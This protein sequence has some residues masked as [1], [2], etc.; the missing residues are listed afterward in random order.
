MGDCSP[1]WFL[2][3]PSYLKPFKLTAS[4]E[5]IL[6]TGGTTLEIPSALGC[7][8]RIMGVILARENISVLVFNKCDKKRGKG[9]TE[10]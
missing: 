1:W 6:C 5:L 8:E 3:R 7:H 10:V 9:F 2:L 4:C